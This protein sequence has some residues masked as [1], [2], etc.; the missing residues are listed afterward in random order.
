MSGNNT[1]QKT[2]AHQ[3]KQ[4]FLNVF[5]QLRDELIHDDLLGDGQPEQTKEWMKRMI[6][7]NVPHGKLNRGMAVL[8]AFKASVG[9]G[10]M[11]EEQIHKA[12]ILGWCIEFLQAYFLVADDI[13]DHSITRRGQPCWY[14][15]PDIGLIAIND[16]IIL[17]SCIYRILKKHFSTSEV[18]YLHDNG[19]YFQIQDDYLDCF[20]D[21]ETIGKIGT[22]I[23]DNKCSWLVVQALKRATDEQKSV[24]EKNYG[25]SDA[26]SV[27]AIKSLYNDLELEKLFKE[28]ETSSYND[29]IAKIEGQDVLP[30]D[31]F[32]PLLNRIYKRTNFHSKETRLQGYLRFTHSVGNLCDLDLLFCS[33]VRAAVDVNE[34]AGQKVS[35]TS[36]SDKTIYDMSKTVLGI[37]LGGGAGSR[38]YPLTKKRAKPA[39]PLGAN[40][41]LIDIP[42]YNASVGG[43]TNRGFVE[44][45]AASQTTSSKKW[46]QGTADAVR[47]YLW[48]FDEACRDG[49]EDF[50]ILSGDHLYRMDYS[51]FVLAHRQA[52]ADITVAALPCREKEAEA[53]GLMKIDDT[54]K[55]VE[56]AEKPKGDALKAMQVDT[57]V[58]GLSKD[59][60]IEKPYIASMGIY[61][62]KASA[63]QDL[64]GKHFTEE[65]DFGSDIIPGAK[66]MGCMFRHIYMMATGR[67]LE[68][69]RHSMMPTWH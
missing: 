1:K 20:G 24:I 17:E 46:F 50:L 26:A 5:D 61:V 40:Y 21:P 29:M 60:A 66:D 42:A 10:E 48:L 19:Q 32:M 3:E 63:L 35:T 56:F 31:V 4:E 67:I 2:D 9:E 6:D 51:Q 34:D 47:Q 8:D 33:T 52:G 62:C 36:P 44:V 39:V 22:D 11:S 38:L 37:I 59:Q 13:M 16:G 14:K 12:R 43:Y 58:L 69:S 68:L 64:L 55:I 23:E 49:V 28:Y 45:L 27:S 25:K 41:R 15:Q 7:Y 53:F 54:G 57:T 65:H 18:R 30:K